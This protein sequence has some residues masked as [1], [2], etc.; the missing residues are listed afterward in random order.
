MDS[1]L[2][3]PTIS[4]GAA[5]RWG[6]SVARSRSSRLAGAAVLALA[7][8]EATN[9]RSGYL[10]VLLALVAAA[11]IIVL[12]ITA[13]SLGSRRR[14]VLWRGLVSFSED[15][16]GGSP[17]FP[18]LV[19]TPKSSVGR[20]GL[21]GGRL[22]VRQDGIHWSAGS[23]LTPG[24]EISGQFVLPWVEVEAIDIGRAPGKLPFLGGT[25]TVSLTGEQVVRGE[26]L[27]QRRALTQALR[28]ATSL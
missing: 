17:A 12:G 25:L 1:P 18:H 13:W 2:R 27:G 6:Q 22:E 3:Q 26:F 19:R 20:R 23:L 16:L 21:S 8:Y 11:G 24:C 5:P 10:D 7:S 15:D 9:G 4:E 28:S 14:G